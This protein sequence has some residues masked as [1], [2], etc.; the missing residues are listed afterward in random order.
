MGL[1]ICVPSF[2]HTKIL[3]KT[4]KPKKQIL[5]SRTLFFS[6]DFIVHQ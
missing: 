3:K 1:K 6:L 2:L 5:F 4:L